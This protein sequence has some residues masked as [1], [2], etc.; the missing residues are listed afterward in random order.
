MEIIFVISV[1]LG[2]ILNSI[3]KI[4]KKALLTKLQFL[5]RPL[6]LT[7]SPT[8]SN[9]LCQPN[10]MT[11]YGM[12]KTKTFYISDCLK[13]SKECGIQTLVLWIR[14]KF[15]SLEYHRDKARVSKNVKD[16]EFFNNN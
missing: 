1:Q 4:L 5:T 9:L 11:N 6:Y 15:K 10:K 7:P 3:N 12:K 2:H 8:T 16:G 14:I 13:I